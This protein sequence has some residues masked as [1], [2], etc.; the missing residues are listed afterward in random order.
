MADMTTLAA[1]TG[2]IKAAADIARTLR[3]LDHSLETAELRLRMVDVL[4]SLADARESVLELESSVKEKDREIERLHGLFAFKGTLVKRKDA[5][6]GTDE[7]GGPVGDPYCTNCWEAKNLPIHL[8]FAGGNA[9]KCPNC[10]TT[11]S[12]SRSRPDP[13][14]PEDPDKTKQRTTRPTR[15]GNW[16][17]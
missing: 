1:I 16:R 4:S 14:L 17:T 13:Q 15:R 5:Y 6:Y 7:N 11:V 3:D 2:S 12:I 10:T 8:V 9:N